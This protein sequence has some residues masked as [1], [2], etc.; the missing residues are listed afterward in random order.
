MV[1]FPAEDHHFC[2]LTIMKAL[3]FSLL[4]TS[5]WAVDSVV[6]I[7]ELNYHPEEPGGGEEWIELHNQM[8]INVDLSGWT[9]TEGIKFTFPEGTTVPGGGYL[10]VAQNPGDPAFTGRA[11]EGPFEGALS[12]SG[13]EI[14]LRDR[15]NR[16]MDSLDYRD[17]GEWP[18]A[19]DGGGATLAKIAGDRL[20]GKSISWQSS[21]KIGGTPGEQNF[22]DPFSANSSGLILHEISPGGAADFFVEITNP[23]DS[24]VDT[25]GYTLVLSGEETTNVDLSAATLNPDGFLVLTAMDL[26][27]TPAD[28]DKVFLYSPDRASLTD[29]RVVTNRLRGISNDHPEKW[30]YPVTATPNAINLFEFE[31]DIVINEISYNPPILEPDA[32]VPPTTSTTA[33]IGPSA[34]WRF[35]QK[36]PAFDQTWATQSHA[37]GGNWESGAGVIAYDLDLGLPITTQLADPAAQFP[38]VVTYY[39]ESD[40]TLTASEAADLDS[41]TFDHLIDDGAVFYLNGIEIERYNMPDGTIT[42]ASFSNPP[43]VGNATRSGEYAL[44][45]P[46]GSAVAGLNRISVEVHQASF[47]SSDIVFGLEVGA[48][49]V[50]DPGSPALPARSSEDQ[51][52]EIFNR[53]DSEVDLSEWSFSEGI[54][55]SFPAG[56]TLASGAYLVLANNSAKLAADHPGIEILGPFSGNLS[57]GGETVTLSDAWKNPADTVRYYD[58]GNWPSKPDAG[59]S[60][61][62]LR[63]PDADNSLPGAWAASDEI[64]RTSWQTYTYRGTA[65]A[66]AVGNDN[67]W[68]EFVFG[69]LEEGEILLDD[70]SVTE[71]P[72]GTATEF[73]TDGSFESGNLSSWRA[74]GTHFDAALVPD[75][76]DAGNQV[77]HLK[78]TGST[79]HMHNHVET[80][81][82]NNE[83]AGN[84]RDYEIS[85]RARWLGGNHLLHTRLYFNRLARTTRLVR[86]ETQGTPGA[87]NSTLVANA[88]PTSQDLAHTPVVPS[89]GQAVTVSVDLSDPDGVASV[90]LNYRVENGSF[91]KTT[92]TQ[93]GS[94]PIWQGDVPGQGSGKVVQFY[95]TARDSLGASSLI[96]KD[97]PESR[98][99]FEVQDGRAATS[100]CI[101]NL[102][103]IMNPADVSFMHTPRHVMSNGRLPC[104]VID[105]EDRVYYNVGVRLKGSERARLQRNRIGF[106]IGFPKDN[107]Y[108]QVHRSIAIDRSE[109]QDVGQRELLFDLMMT[110]SGAVSGEHNDLAYVISPDPTHTSPAILQLA[111]FGSQFLGDQFKNC[112]DGTVY[113]YEL[114]YY[115][116]TTDSGGYKIPEPDNVVGRNIGDLGDNPEDYRWTYLIKN[117]Q[118]FDDF[119]PAMALA[120]QFSKS[121]ADFNASVDQVLDVDQWLRALAYSC[122]TGAGD[123]FYA[124]ANH[125]GQFYGRPDGKVLYFPHD[126]DFSFS[127]TRSITENS[128]LQRIITNQA[129]RRAYLA[130]LY[131]ICATVYN[132]T[133][134][135]PWVDHFN[136]CVPGHPGFS[137]DLN[138]IN[139]RSNYILGQINSQVSQIDFSIASN[140][141][142]DFEVSENP[143]ILAGNGWVDL[144][145]IRLASSGVPIP[146]TWKSTRQWEISL[147]LAN[148][149]NVVALQAFDRIGNLLGTDSITITRTGGAAPPDAS[150]LVVSEL[151]YNP[152]GQDEGAE[153]LELLN[154]GSDELDL[155]GIRFTEGVIFT[156]P[157]GTTLAVGQRIL[158]V[159]DLIAFEKEFGSGF[160]IAGAFEGNLANSGETISLARA[161]GTVI[162]SFTYSDSAPW[163]V[164]ADGDGF[165]LTLTVPECA[166]DHNL[167]F[168]WRASLRPGGSP[169]TTDAPD[170]LVWKA[171]FGNPADDAD[172]DGD[173]WTVVEEFYFGGAPDRQD[174]LAPGYSFDRSAGTIT[175]TLT[176]RK[177]VEAKL[178][179]EASPDLKAWSDHPDAMVI[180]SQGTP[181]DPEVEKVTYAIPLSEEREFLRFVFK[182][183]I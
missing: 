23:S 89:A 76:D 123:S 171:S 142:E 94:S 97:G 14:E 96:P 44:T 54:G 137:D 177:G 127:V 162:Q 152:P 181:T 17:S 33:L 81:F 85:F 36:R 153:F 84:G 72:D 9:L 49:T 119:K 134:M 155:T 173:G 91:V 164:E 64:A 30:L 112:D 130:H 126:L 115:P 140:N 61:L 105:R 6:T 86:P 104:T 163:P 13:E 5:A 136:E 42:S 2:P 39:F 79:E 179:L 118:E 125:N 55:Y 1:I 138:Y 67:Q 108:R 147:A 38:S 40:F 103:I 110:S 25:D 87:P 37:I 82:K 145:E 141:G 165:S 18:V 102:R 122:A 47:S 83:R 80:T 120:K 41:L 109:G 4:T 45:V 116:T 92:M 52:I 78:A 159:G 100:P 88:G 156:F 63:D 101:N 65:S 58:G 24:P 128:E 161:D 169:G 178:I 98:A 59:G 106:N 51:W 50:T 170:Y 143:V 71:D 129:Y 151:Y 10:I 166:P 34:V 35:N 62:E 168:N 69:L 74:L 20:S 29:A 107:L 21:R 175:A 68:R 57:R 15:A 133:W 60:T 172:P 7:N 66:S 53:G 56:T 31:T 26:G 124:N 75:P 157:A 73:L 160:N 111:R 167:A 149:E 131:D 117:N 22:P 174:D 135:A 11:V 43:G 158:L 19:P 183:G 77:L 27:L 114:I 148:G 146:I 180:S 32:G 48:L 113:E 150:N 144:H 3:L 139:S 70:L 176:R 182:T 16:L 154:I 28:G 8:A 46:A 90:D 132:R 121:S 99:M 95:L 93:V 12:N